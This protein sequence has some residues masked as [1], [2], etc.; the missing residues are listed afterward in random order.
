MTK[1]Q[2]SS[3]VGVFTNNQLTFHR[4]ASYETCEGPSSNSYW[5]QAS[6]KRVVNPD[7]Q[8]SGKAFHDNPSR[9]H[10]ATHQDA[11]K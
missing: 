4:S 5:H 8:A 10:I 3:Q 11:L 6:S 2:F 9:K 7:S 1:N